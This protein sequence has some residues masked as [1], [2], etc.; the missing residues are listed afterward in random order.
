MNDLLWNPLLAW[1]LLIGCA[2]LIAGGVGWSLWR[3]LHDR[4]RA[5]ISGLFR[6][7]ALLLLGLMLLQ[8]QRRFE[9]VTILK[10]QLAVLVDLSL[11]HI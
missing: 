2:L 1:P 4:R 6:L 10:P 3:G 9:E 11:I 5:V 8:P 7:G